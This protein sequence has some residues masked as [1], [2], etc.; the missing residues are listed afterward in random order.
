MLAS[1]YFMAG[2]ILLQMDRSRSPALA[3]PSNPDALGQCYKAE[4]S[5]KP[6]KK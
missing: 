2:F 5:G 4:I 6:Y 3:I 1:S